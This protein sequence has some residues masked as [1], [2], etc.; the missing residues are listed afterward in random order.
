MHRF[1]FFA[2]M[3]AAILVGTATAD[4]ATR[5]KPGAAADRSAVTAA[6][7]KPHVSRPA[8]ATRAMARRP[9]ESVDA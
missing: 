7:H 6:K 9:R 3:A 4:A 5:K 1:V 2:M 8:A